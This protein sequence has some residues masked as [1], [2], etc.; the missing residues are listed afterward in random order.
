[1][2]QPQQ[3]IAIPTYNRR[4]LVEAC[5]SCLGRVEDLCNWQVIIADDCSTDYDIAELAKTA[6]FGC[7]IIRNEAN[8]GC[9]RNTV[10]LLRMCLERGAERILLLDS[11][12]IVSADALLFAGRVF[13]RTDGILS[14]YNSVLHR[15]VEPVDDDLVR[16]QSIGG[17]ATVWD[18]RVLEDLIDSLET[19]HCWDWRICE[20]AQEKD[21]RLIVARNSHAQHVGVGGTNNLNFGRLEYGIGFSVETMEQAA[22]IADAHERLMLAQ[23]QYWDLT[24]P[25]KIVRW[26]NSIVKRLPKITAGG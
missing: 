18:A 24:K 26:R 3:I 4:G 12:M 25:P 22:A 15:P 21:I 1:M 5:L 17:A 16:K 11:D 19:D 6:S 13:D 8:L 20:R 9:D 7:E 2:Q 23:S 10:A 14:L